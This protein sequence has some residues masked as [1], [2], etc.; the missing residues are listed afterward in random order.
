MKRISLKL[1][2]LIYACLVIII[3]GVSVS[4]SVKLVADDGMNE[5]F[6]HE[7]ES[8]YASIVTLFDLTYQGEWSMD[9]DELM[10]GDMKVSELEGYLDALFK[11]TGY[12]ISIC[13]GSK[14]LISNIKDESGNRLSGTE[15]DAVTC[16]T[17]L[18]GNVYTAPVDLY[19]NDVMAYYAP[20]IDQRGQVIGM[21]FVGVDR[22]IINQESNELKT[23]SMSIFLL[24]LVFWIPITFLLLSILLNPIKRLNQQMIQMADKDF[25]LD[26]HLLKIKSRTEIGQMI[27]SIKA[28]QKVIAEMTHTVHNEAE[29]VDAEARGCY[30]KVSEV[31]SSMQEIVA[32][33]EE[34]S[35]GMEETSAGAEQI[36]TVAQI[37]SEE[38]KKLS[39]KADHGKKK[40]ETI[41]E[42]AKALMEEANQRKSEADLQIKTGEGKITQAMEEA[43]KIDQIRI[44]ADTIGT[45]ADQTKLLALN[46]S[47]EAARAGDAGRGFS[48][49]A[50]EI[51]SLSL[52][53]SEA[54]H[55]IYEVVNISL[56]AVSHLI[57]TQETQ[58]EFVKDAMS[59][60]FEKLNVTGKIYHEDSEYVATLVSHL[61]ESS[62]HMMQQFDTMESAMSDMQKAMAESAEGSSE[63]ANHVNSIAENVTAIVTSSEET[64]VSAENLKKYIGQYQS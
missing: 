61:E 35:A 40:A 55:K 39:E 15:V 51:Q 42:R 50:D 34:I 49:V 45:I 13:S 52:A 64:K 18:D 44:L 53:S 62:K 9:Q 8:A 27:T 60:L 25:R 56:E 20:I 41:A 47:I 3:N 57:Q 14:R 10:K 16:A 11:K 17:V 48:V 1:I 6:Q 28:M 37:I 58:N 63:I 26:E 59:G 24:H 22:S 38:V 54:V 23:K 31:N 4:K 12:Y 7:V 5:I 29:Q 32:T 43:K 36:V 46:A 21:F 30:I 2:M 19:G 33:T